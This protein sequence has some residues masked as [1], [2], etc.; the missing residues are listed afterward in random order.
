[1]IVGVWG[2]EG[3]EICSV[4]KGDRE[5]EQGGD[6]YSMKWGSKEYGNVVG[7]YFEG[8]TLVGVYDGGVCVGVNGSWTEIPTLSA[9]DMDTVASAGDGDVL[10][11]LLL[12]FVREG[13]RGVEGRIKNWKGDW[14]HGTI[15]AVQE[16]FDG[17]NKGGLTGYDKLGEKEEEIDRVMSVVKK[18]GG[19]GGEKVKGMKEV[20]MDKEP[21]NELKALALGTKAVRARTSLQDARTP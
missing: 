15:A 3:V 4:P 19:E 11:V 10:K 14:T 7:T 12:K 20:R 9:N 21:S 6:G 17:K 13:G 2:E 16:I 5:I 18:L 8:E 1:M